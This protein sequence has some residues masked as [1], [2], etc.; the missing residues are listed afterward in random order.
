MTVSCE[1]EGTC[2]LIWPVCPRFSWLHSF[3][4]HPKYTNLVSKRHNDMMRREPLVNNALLLHSYR[5]CCPPSA[6]QK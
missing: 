3:T 6:L 2:S 5:K 1:G 4:G